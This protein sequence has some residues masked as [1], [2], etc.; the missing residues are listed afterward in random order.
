MTHPGLHGE[1]LQVP[2]L[3]A[4]DV[5]GGLAKVKR[6]FGAVGGGVDDVAHRAPAAFVEHL[7]AAPLRTVD[8]PDSAVGE[9]EVP[10]LCTRSPPCGPMDTSHACAGCMTGQRAGA[11]GVDKDAG[12][13]ILHE[14]CAARVNG[15]RY[16]AAGCRGVT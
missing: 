5:R 15:V 2:E 16:A 11:Q 8:V 12:H 7:Q 3:P 4:R 10:L 9:P 6:R 13:R 14:T 1:P